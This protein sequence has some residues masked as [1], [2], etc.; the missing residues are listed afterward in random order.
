MSGEIIQ[1]KSGVRRQ[2]DI[3]SQQYHTYAPYSTAFNNNDE[4]RITIQSQDLYVLPSD[5]YI[6]IEFSVT[7]PNAEAI[8]ANN[9]FFSKYFIA[10]MFS[11]MR[12]EL[13]GFEI[14]RCKSPGITSLL[15]TNVACKSN[16]FSMMNLFDL[17]N[18]IA[19]RA[20][21]YRMILP[22]RFIFGF[23]DDFNKIVLNSKHE[24][25]L[26]RHRT[27]LNMYREA[28]AQGGLN[29]QFNVNKILWKIPH[30]E[31]SDGAKL[32]MLQTVA[33]NEELR[34]VFR[35]WDL[36]ELPVVPQARRN[37]WAVKT[38]NKVNKPRYVVVALQTN[39]NNVAGNVTASQ[40]D[41]CNISNI[42][43]YLNNERFPYDDYDLNFNEW[44]HHELYLNWMNIQESYYNGTGGLNP[45]TS[46]MGFAPILDNVIFAFDC[47]KTDE[48]IK[49][50]MV[51]VR[52]EIES[53]ENIPANTTAYCLI[54]HDNLIRYSPF[55]S[56]VH[57]EI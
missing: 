26:V 54:I 57:R 36:Y 33:R 46:Q 5:S 41:H 47:T 16:D 25:I 23:C 15:K 51:D 30:I 2:D 56:L 39:R 50:G 43:L 22:L 55:T 52:L 1:V 29:L 40:F 11:E 3:I 53:R 10:H 19:I 8:P 17:H 35:S 38:T 32:S 6:Y 48:S 28:P 37:T 13:N 20:G 34:M 21:N 49:P 45:T 9:A 12:Y 24:L 44:S 7:T 4:I 42:K 18:D 14:D 31:L 27:N